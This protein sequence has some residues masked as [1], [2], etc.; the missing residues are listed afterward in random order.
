MSDEI[1]KEE[2]LADEVLLLQ[3]GGEMPEV[4][5]HAAVIFLCKDLDGPQLI[6]DEGDLLVLK[7]AVVGR[8]RK[9]ILRD[10]LPENRFTSIYRGLERSYANW[11]RLQGYAGREGLEGEVEKV[12]VEV[13]QSLATFLQQEYED[14]VEKGQESAINCS[15]SQLVGFS[16][17]VGLDLERELPHWQQLFV[18]R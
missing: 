13:A 6:L 1:S 11:H 10:L 8:F 16:A 3:D 7:K 15:S 4:A 18:E 5:Y 12:G 2:W 17:D 14:V 9:I